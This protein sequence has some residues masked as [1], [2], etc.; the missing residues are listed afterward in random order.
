MIE[1]IL[2]NERCN[3]KVYRNRCYRNYIQ[4]VTDNFLGGVI[5]VKM[6]KDFQL[7]NSNYEGVKGQ[8]GLRCHTD[9]DR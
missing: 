1:V 4:V 3:N 7:L 2:R 6:I 5:I 9:S 8:H